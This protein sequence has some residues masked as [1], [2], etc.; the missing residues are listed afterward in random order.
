MSAKLYQPF[1]SFNFSNKQCF[2]SGESLTSTEEKIH[3]FPT[4][5]MNRY[6]L[7]DQPFKMLDE[8]MATYKDLLIPCSATINDDYLEPL[9]TQ[10]ADAFEAGYEGVKAMDDLKLFQ[11]A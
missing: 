3:V 6:N 9:E 10:V 8:S 1:N 4:W 11:W 2:L 7:N 5:L